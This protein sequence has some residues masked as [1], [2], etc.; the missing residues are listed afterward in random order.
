MAV[1]TRTGA[2]KGNEHGDNAG[3]LPPPE[4]G[5]HSLYDG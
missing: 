2:S 5:D 4:A 3:G 1:S